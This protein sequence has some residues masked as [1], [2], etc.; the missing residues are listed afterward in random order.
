MEYITNKNSFPVVVLG[1][2]D[3]ACKAGTRTIFEGCKSAHVG[4]LAYVVSRFAYKIESIHQV[5]K[6]TLHHQSI[7]QSINQ[8]ASQ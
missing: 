6:Q 3:G 4:W 7:N 1:D 2:F 5:N 8:M